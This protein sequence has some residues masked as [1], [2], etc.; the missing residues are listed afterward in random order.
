MTVG[1][2]VP[3]VE[4]QLVRLLNGDDWGSEELAASVRLLGSPGCNLSR[5]RPKLAKY[6]WV[7]LRTALNQAQ[8]MERRS[9]EYLDP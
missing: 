2:R 4:S 3:A 9:L 1:Q 7:R 6:A 5:I 8:G